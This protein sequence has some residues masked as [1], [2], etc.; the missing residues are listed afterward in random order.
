MAS[1]SYGLAASRFGAAA[2]AKL[3][4]PAIA[5]SPEDQLRSPL[6]AFIKD[7]ATVAG[8]AVD[9]VG[10]TT[11]SELRIRPDY[12]VSSNKVLVGF[13]ELKAPGKGADPRRFSDP[14][15]KA[16][17]AR[18]KAL[19]NLLYTDGNSFSLWRDGQL[20]G[21][22]MRFDRDIAEAGAQAVAPDALF[23]LLVDFLTWGPTSPPNAKRLADVAAR[24][25]RLLRDEV[26][27][28]I[29]QGNEH[30]ALLQ[31][32]WRNLLFPNA[33]V[34][35]FADGY[36]QAV[37]FGLLIARAFDVDVKNGVDLAALRL[38]K[39]NSLI[40]AAL[41]LLTESQ[42]TQRALATS[43]GAL[44][45]VLGEVDWHR[46]SRDKPEAW[47]YFYEEFLEIYDNKLRKLTGSYYTPPEVVEAL[48]R[49]VDEAL[50]GPLFHRAG[51]LASADVTIADP[52]VGT[53][54]FLLGVLRQI[55]T[56]VRAD[57]GDGAVGGAILAAC[58][59]MFG[60][61]LQFGPFAV[62]QLRLLAEL[63]SL[64]PA[65]ATPPTVNLYVT[66]T[67]DNPFVEDEQ[68][69]QIVEPVAKSRRDANR[70]KRG[71]PITVVI[72]NPPYKEKAEGR[73]GWIEMGAGRELTAPL[74][75]WKAPPSWG[76]GAHGKHL[77]NLYVYFWRWATLKVFGSGQ[78][79]ATGVPD[80]DEEG[81]ICFITV[82]GFLNG[83]GFEKMRD[84]LRRTCTAI[85]IV[86]C[87]PEGH[88]P[89][90]A[91]RIFQGVQQPVC[92][93]LAARKLQTSNQTPAAVKYTA[94][95]K[96]KRGEKFAALSK[97]SLDGAEWEDC[98]DEWRAPF[99]P[100]ARG[101][102]G[103]LPRLRD[104]F[105]YNGSG[106]MPGRTWVIAPDVE[107]LERRWSKLVAERDPKKKEVLFHPHLRAGALGDKH[108]M[109]APSEPL[110]GHE[111]RLQ[112]VAS[113]TGSGSDG[114]R[115]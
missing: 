18:L 12:A 105:D 44:T 42:E 109:K 21:S 53:G 8:Q 67:L 50:R 77:K 100:A 64:L 114:A 89:E 103:E 75:R 83:P 14:H 56:N 37:T 11:L 17:W 102:W 52:A 110:A 108:S 47:L 39:S 99:L 72:G 69:P 85:W 40:G 2:K 70:V 73:G 61:E 101:L 78:Y 80:R 76:V 112:A 55:A 82:A 63:R 81:L 36:A 33:S 58:K 32:D 45:R 107:S 68:L 84:D 79:A 5:G 74:D 111:R 19:P 31:N 57:Q 15:D 106:V 3:K 20:V 94:L 7:V 93:V 62:A 66:N 113:D 104:L 46:I 16:Q 27:E 22:V 38:K 1:D 59:R 97:L 88:Q 91:T 24:L 43:L 98:S 4:N 26:T 6:E 60:F 41:G 35:Q 92:I 25:C 23:P 115:R 95:P 29:E 30:L 54:T 34:E 48:V 10:E 28:Q 96:S 9:L 51:G 65:G 71:Q 87:S 13:I 86:D 90:V 49:L